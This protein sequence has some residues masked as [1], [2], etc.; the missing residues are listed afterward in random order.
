MTSIPDSGWL[1]AIHKVAWWV[2]AAIA[3][4]ATV[5]LV[6][7]HF[8]APWFRH[9]PPTVTAGIGVGGILFYCLLVFRW[10]DY[11][12]HRRRIKVRR[13]IHQLSDQQ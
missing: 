2:S 4:A 13:S 3:V 6:L 5:V 10:I 9:L 1:T 8:E 12:S 11:V 7:V